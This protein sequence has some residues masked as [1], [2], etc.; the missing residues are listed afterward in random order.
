MQ[1]WDNIVNTAMIGTDKKQVSAAELPADLAEPVTV[2]YNNDQADKEQKFLQLAAVAFNFRQTGVTALQK[3]VSISPAPDEEKAYCSIVAA[4][5]L[6]DILSEESIP[7]LKFWLQHCDRKQQVIIPETLPA[8]LGIGTQNKNLQVLIASCCGKRGEWLS[9]F[10]EA[11]NFSST[12]TGEELWQTGTPDQRKI[13]FKETRKINPTLA[14]EW[15]QQTWPQEDANTKT[16]FLELLPENISEEDIAF[17]DSLSTEKSKKV[18]EE[19]IRLLK[20]IPGSAI[21]KQYQELLQQCVMIKKEKTLLGMV[22]KTSLQFKLPPSFDETI[23]KTGIEKLSSSKEISDEEF[24]IYQLIQS[25]PPSF[26]QNQLERDPETVIDLFQKD[27]AGKKMIP[28]L[29]SAITRFR[30]TSWAQHFMQ[31][32]ETFYIDIIPLLQVQQQEAYSNK[33]FDKYPDNIIQYATQRETEWS[34]ELSKNIFKHTAK[35]PYQYNRS[36]YNQ[37][38]HL[39]PGSAIAELEKCTPAEE[40][41]RNTWSNTSDYIIKLITLKIQTLKAFNS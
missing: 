4:Q 1:F 2:I 22:S 29:V 31:H 6:K 30:D 15:L 40:N 41:L 35:N 21:V 34:V 12:Q 11:W 5:T 26:W 18:K 10:N 36:F 16:G 38:I 23:F 25:A 20:Q 24:I 7:L 39:I 14:R 33:F 19:A 3:E 32:S 13:I 28:A 27:T 37:H 8:L 9:G 17:L